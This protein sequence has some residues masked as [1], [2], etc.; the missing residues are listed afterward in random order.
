MAM[1][2]KEWKIKQNVNVSL[3]YLFGWYYYP[4][5]D[6]KVVNFEMYVSDTPNH[7]FSC[8]FSINYPVIGVPGPGNPPNYEA[9]LLLSR[10][11]IEMLH[12]VEFLSPDSLGV[13]EKGRTKYISGWWWLEHDWSIFPHIGNFIIPIDFHFFLRGRYT[14]NQ[15]WSIWSD[16]WGKDRRAPSTVHP[17]PDRYHPLPI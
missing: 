8:W 6:P 11:L 10:M 16:T 7:P 9:N 15:I 2:K 4:K 5:L 17:L 3:L 12:D 1:A 13:P 14:T